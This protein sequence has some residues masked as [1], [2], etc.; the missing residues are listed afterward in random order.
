MN[1]CKVLKRY[2]LGYR[3]TESEPPLF[4]IVVYMGVHLVKIDPL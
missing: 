2:V 1:K 4:I 3:Y